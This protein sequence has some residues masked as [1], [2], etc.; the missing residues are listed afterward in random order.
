MDGRVGA[1]R[2]ALDGDGFADVAIL[3]YA[4]KYASGFYGPFR[5]AADSAPQSGDRRG[6]QMDPGNAR[7][8]LKEVRLDLDEG[9]DMVMVKPAL[10]YLD[11]ITRV[12][13]ARRRA[14]RRLQRQRRVRD[15]QS[16]GARRLDRRDARDARDPH[17]D[18]ARRRRP[19]PHLP[20][21]R[22]R[23]RSAA[24]SEPRKSRRST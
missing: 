7:E 13:A 6:Y 2:S 9:A 12:R 5:E 24:E 11:V 18:Q 8:A 14:G 15:G 20:R 16:R 19:D 17:L 4:A 23:A 1:I 21:D 10:S 22:S 3:S